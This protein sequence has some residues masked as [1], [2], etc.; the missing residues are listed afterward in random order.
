MIRRKRL[1][2]VWCAALIVL[3]CNKKQDVHLQ[4]KPQ[5][6]AQIPPALQPAAAQGDLP[7]W[8]LTAIGENFPQYHVPAGSDM[9]GFWAKAVHEGSTSFLCRGDFKGDGLDDYAIVLI[10]QNNWRFVIFDQRP[11]GG[12]FPAYV[13]RPRLPTELPKG[14]SE[15]TDIEAPQELILEKLAKGQ[16]WAPE[17]GDEPY[18]VNLQTDGERGHE[19]GAWSPSP[20]PATHG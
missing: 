10:A 14:R 9:T 20:L 4:P 18:E 8:L 3:G 5:E 2:M 1:I 13:A 16:V 7:P 11:G 15:N 17:A 19:L 6:Q 12:F